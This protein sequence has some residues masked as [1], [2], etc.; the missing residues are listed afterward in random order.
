[1]NIAEHCTCK[2]ALWNI[3]RN[4]S[5]QFC[6]EICFRIDADK[7]FASRFLPKAKINSA[8]NYK[9]L[10]PKIDSPLYSFPII[11]C[12]LIGHVEYNVN[13]VSQNRI[14]HALL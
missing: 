14:I 13:R 8:A 10:N 2:D 7:I 3:R 1:M 9:R 4:S 5:E 6:D 11:R 12:M